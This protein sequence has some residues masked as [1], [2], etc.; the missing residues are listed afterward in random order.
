MKRQKKSSG[1]SIPWLSKKKAAAASVR[2]KRPA[3]LGWGQR[4]LQLLIL[5]L[6]VSTLG[7]IAVGFVYL[8]RYVRSLPAVAQKTGP[9]EL[10]A[11]PEWISNELQEKIVQAAGGDSFPL[12][13]GQAKQIA[14]RLKSFSWMIDP[15]VQTTETTIR[16]EAKYRKPVAIIEYGGKKFYLVRVEP[17]SNGSVTGQSGVMIL[18]YVPI[19]KLLLPRITG[20]DSKPPARPGE[21]WYSAEIN[22]VL[23]LLNTLGRM[24]QISTPEKPLLADLDRIDISNAGGKKSTSK[25]HTILYA[26]DGTEVWWGAAYGESQRYLEATEQEKIGSLYTFYKRYGTLCII[27]RG[28]GQI[29][30]LRSPQKMFPRPIN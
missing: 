22:A 30:E 24:D 13:L 6:V 17:D 4:L 8:E 9:L 28:V 12:D 14:E 16:I 21:M 23:E 18:D 27:N 10:I 29:I 11:P 3:P 25:P 26:K 7:G 1:F 2:R 5:L 20:Y 19:E 15:S